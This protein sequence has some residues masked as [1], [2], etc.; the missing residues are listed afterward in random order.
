[1]SIQPHGYLRQVLGDDEEVLL[2]ARPHWFVLLS[3]TF[4][5]IVL[6]AAVLIGAT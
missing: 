5:W 6:F 2:I 3:K 1:M 4:L